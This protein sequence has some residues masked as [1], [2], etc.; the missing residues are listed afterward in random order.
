M[1]S[2]A[3]ILRQFEDNLPAL[4]REI[5]SLRQAN[6]ALREEL[7]RTLKLTEQNREAV[8]LLL[9]ALHEDDGGYETRFGTAAAAEDGLKIALR[10]QGALRLIHDIAYDR[11]GFAEA[12]HLGQLVDELYHLAGRALLGEDVNPPQGGADGNG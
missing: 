6:L 11:D 1:T 5:L 2:E 10:Y 3:D 4:A 7:M 9:A 12:E 8:T